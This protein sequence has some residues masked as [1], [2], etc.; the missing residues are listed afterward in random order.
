MSVENLAVV[1]AIYDAFATGDI[2]GVLARFHPEIVW[3]EAENFPY[4]D[5]NPYRGPKAVAE[6]VFMRCA[7]EWDGFAVEID[8]ILDA[9]TAI[10]ALGRYAGVYR[11][12]GRRQHPQM[13]HVWRVKDGLATE[14]QQYVDTLHVARC[15]GA[16]PG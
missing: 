2:A 7:T 8:E 14:F 13:V 15:V 3:R 12:T 11:A 10:L 9:G 16:V 1:R 5:R 6:G 4:A